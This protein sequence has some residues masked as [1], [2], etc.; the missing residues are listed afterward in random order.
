MKAFLDTSV[1]VATFYADHEHH[2]PS[3]KLFV[4]QEKKSAAAAP[5][6]RARGPTGRPGS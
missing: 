2:E 6:A 3:F 5:W 4:R 1:L